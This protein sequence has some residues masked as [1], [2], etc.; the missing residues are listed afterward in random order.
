MIR[1]RGCP[2]RVRHNKVA[3]TGRF[4]RLKST[5][6][7]M[8]KPITLGRGKKSIKD[9]HELYAYLAGCMHAGL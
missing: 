6:K 3:R 1:M 9:E 5:R 7:K 2:L 8:P 4:N